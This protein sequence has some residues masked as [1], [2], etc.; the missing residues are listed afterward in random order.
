[1]QGPPALAR[2]LSQIGLVENEQDGFDHQSNLLPGPVI[3][4]PFRG[5]LAVGRLYHSRRHAD[6][7]RGAAAAAQ[8]VDRAADRLAAAEQE[9]AAA[10]AARTAAE[11]ASQAAVTAE[12]SARNGRRD[13]EQ[14]LERARA[15]LSSLRNQAATATARLAAA[16]DQ[17]ARITVERDEAVA[18]LAQVRAAQTALPDIAELRAA[19]DRARAA[20]SAVRSR[21]AAARSR[22][23]HRWRANTPPGSTAG[24]SSSPNAPAGR[25]GPRMPPTG[26]P[27]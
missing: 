21:E 10:R 19:V 11:T 12:Q 23:R 4:L 24:G 18:A 25:S 15:S 14:K 27:T 5:D 13:W 1:M 26:S 9:A 17:L 22:A 8:P 20:L 7:G 3:G 2:A 16:D 6:P